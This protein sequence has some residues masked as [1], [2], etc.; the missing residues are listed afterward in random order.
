MSDL[1][2]SYGSVRALRGVSLTVAD[3][4]CAAILGANGAGKSSLLKAISGLVPSTGGVRLG[5]AALRGSPD[6]RARRGLGH[7]L[8]GRHVF[9]ELTVRENIEVGLPRGHRWS[10][11]TV[12][13]VLDAFPLLKSKLDRRAGELSGGEQ[14]TVSIGR[15]LVGRP[16][17]LLM[18]EPSLGLSPRVVDQL[19]SSIAEIRANRGMTLL[20]AEQSLPLAMTLASYFYV[21]RTGTLAYEGRGSQEELWDEAQKAYLG[22][23]APLKEFG[24]SS[25]DGPI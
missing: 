13:E 12:V 3:G 4:A 8:E 25:A 6:S 2:V 20:V 5:S 15:C 7:V 18:D 24:V 9:R 10:D 14:Q 17:V 23:E 16:D 22:A 1:R 21:L 19:A 11:D